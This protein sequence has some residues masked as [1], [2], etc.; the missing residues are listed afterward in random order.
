MKYCFLIAISLKKTYLIEKKTKDTVNRKCHYFINN[1]PSKE[2]DLFIFQIFLT[3]SIHFV[4]TFMRHYTR[5][6]DWFL[7]L[8]GHGTLKNRQDFGWS[9]I[10]E[11]G[12]GPSTDLSFW[13][14]ARFR[15][16]IESYVT[17]DLNFCFILMTL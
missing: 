17:H 6:T 4:L 16:K 2:G 7:S 12:P 9:P 5:C 8:P 10:L 3:H 1:F 14:S 11:A 13:N 15:D